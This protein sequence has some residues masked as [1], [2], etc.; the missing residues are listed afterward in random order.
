[1]RR[2]F[3]FTHVFRNRALLFLGQRTELGSHESRF[4][5]VLQADG[6]GVRAMRLSLDLFDSRLLSATQ[7]PIQPHAMGL[8]E[9]L[10]GS[11]PGASD[12]R[13]FRGPG[14]DGQH[15]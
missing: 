3:L 11:S 12:L 15:R 7:Q 4:H 13:R 9:C 1:M 2:K 8:S 10:K 6:A 5:A 14:D